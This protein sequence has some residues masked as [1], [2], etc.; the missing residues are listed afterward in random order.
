MFRIPKK[1]KLASASRKMLVPLKNI[2]S[3]EHKLSVI[4]FKAGKLIVKLSNDEG[5]GEIPLRNDCELVLYVPKKVITEVD[6][7]TKE[8]KFSRMGQTLDDMLDFTDSAM[9]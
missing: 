8:I 9:N 6:L 4:P 2:I 7:L 3:I 1:P 5:L